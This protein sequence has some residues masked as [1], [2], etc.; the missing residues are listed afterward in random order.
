MSNSARKRGQAV[1][2]KLFGAER[3]FKR[4]DTA[5]DEFTI[6]HLGATTR[7]EFR[8]AHGVVGEP[9]RPPAQRHAHAHARRGAVGFVGS[10][11]LSQ[12]ARRNGASPLMA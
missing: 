2:K 10:S 12:A 5:L 6:E 4:G 8:E 3:K 9:T 11:R 7:D 1:Y